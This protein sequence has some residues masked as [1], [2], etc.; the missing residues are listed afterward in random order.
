MPA[1]VG[2]TTPDPEPLMQLLAEIGPTGIAAAAIVVFFGALIQGSVGMGFGLF[3]SP[4][5]AL[6]EPRLIPA[7]VLTL[8]TVVAIHPAWRG[9]ADINTHELGVG[10]IGRIVGAVVSGA[11]FAYLYV[12]RDRLSL[13]F[14]IIVIVAVAL[15]LSRIRFALNDRN[16]LI[17]STVSGAMG[18]F[19]GIGAPPMGLIYQRENPAK[20]RATLNAFFGLSTGISFLV[21][22]AYGVLGTAHFVVAAAISPALG[23][24]V[25]AAS[26]VKSPPG[27]NLRM[28]I[29]AICT[30][31]S[32]ILILRGLGYA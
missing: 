25:I 30:I 17:A 3:A 5:L 16:L 1:D 19:T 27:E 9:R 32:L 21:L 11:A 15:S 23:A 14:G 8:G 18:T 20:V 12:D 2:A 31:S 10:I 22:A 28:V 26:F 4:L 7:I 29:L 24:G 13:A 6:I